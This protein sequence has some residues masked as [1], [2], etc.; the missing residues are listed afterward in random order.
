MSLTYSKRKKVTKE[1]KNPFNVKRNKSGY[2]AEQRLYVAGSERCDLEHWRAAKG[3][4]IP[5]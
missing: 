1:N 2:V 4:N 5:S 3:T